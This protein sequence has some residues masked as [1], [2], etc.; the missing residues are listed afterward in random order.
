MAHR[1][2]DPYSGK[3][4]SLRYSRMK[5]GRKRL[6]RIRDYYKGSHTFPWPVVYDKYIPSEY[7]YF[8]VPAPDARLKRNYRGKI[9]KYLKAQCHRKARRRT[10]IYDSTYNKVS[11]FWWE[12]W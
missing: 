7:N 9:S 6:Q 10:E 3:S 11:E 1:Y 4:K 8:Y 2:V 12:L 5:K